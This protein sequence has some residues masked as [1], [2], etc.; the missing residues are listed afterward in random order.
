MTRIVPEELYEIGETGPMLFQA[1]EL[2]RLE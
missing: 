1:A 2:M